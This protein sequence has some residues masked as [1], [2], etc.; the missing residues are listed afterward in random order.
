MQNRVFIVTGANGHLGS[1]LVRLLK[2]RKEE[3]RG[4]VLAG[5]KVHDSPL[6]RYFAGDVTRKESL[7]PL[8]EDV[9]DREA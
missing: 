9:G 2:S 8:F 5:E 7:R 1:A 4:L 6:V 3:V